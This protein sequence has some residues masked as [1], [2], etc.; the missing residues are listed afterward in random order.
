MKKIVIQMHMGNDKCRSKAMKIAAAF[1]GVV[2]VSLEGESRD[3]VVVT[4]DQIDCVCLAKKLR[5]KFCYVNL[6]SVDDEK[7]S[8]TSNEGGEAGEEQK[9]VEISTTSLKKLSC[10]EQSYHPPC[11]PYYIVYDPYPISCYWNRFDQLTGVYDLVY[12]DPGQVTQ[13]F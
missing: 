7:P 8:T 5:K 1:Q 12:V 11:T 9:D 4:G 3:Q 10:C 13:F 6:L 2:S